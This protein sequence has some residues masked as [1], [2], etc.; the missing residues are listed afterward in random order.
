MSTTGGR[1]VALLAVLVVI[2]LTGCQPPGADQGVFRPA[3]AP[4]S[5]ARAVT[6]VKVVAAGDIV[7][8]PGE[9][10]TA[11]TCQHQA[12][13]DL[14]TEIDPRRVLA[15][16]DLQY[17]RGALAAFRD[18]YADSWGAFKRRTRPIPGNH[19]YGTAD[20]SG[21]FTYFGQEPPGY[22]AITVGDWRVYLLDSNCAVIDCA[23][24][25]AWLRTDLEA[26]PVTCSAMALHFPRYSSGAHGSQESVR[27]FWRIAYRHHVDLALAGHDHHYERFAP[28]DSVGNRRADGIVSFVVGTGGRSLYRRHGTA[29]GSRYFRA[30]TFGV[31]VLRLGDGEFGWRFRTTGGAG[32]DA[33]SR[34]CR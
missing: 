1:I 21:Y 6:G 3:A 14:V 20:A 25:R 9:P 30:D 17:E 22:R 26:N 4:H 15:L 18:T 13:A 12:T 24:E 33:G 31:L 28:M 10:T 16:G 29:P 7:C 19:E 27:G 34:T 2:G 11:A 8:A 5:S 32:R 23:A